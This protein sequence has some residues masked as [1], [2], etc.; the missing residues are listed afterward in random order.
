V[1]SIA[2]PAQGKGNAAPTGAFVRLSCGGDGGEAPVMGGS[3]EAPARDPWRMGPHA[4]AN[5]H[6]V[7]PAAMADRIEQAHDWPRSTARERSSRWASPAKWPKTKP[8]RSPP[9][10]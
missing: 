6:T 1:A 10:A 2:V 8:G 4:R 3:V 7:R 5:V 9:V